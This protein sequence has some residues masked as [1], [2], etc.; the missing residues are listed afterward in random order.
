MAKR[1]FYVCAGI[2][3]LAAAYHL[4]ATRAESHAPGHSP[5]GCAAFWD[6]STDMERIAVATADGDVYWA[7]SDSPG[8]ESWMP[9]Q[10]V[11]SPIVAF[12]GWGVGNWGASA[13][14]ENGDVWRT[15]DP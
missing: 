3:M 5:V 11:P 1:F 4:G 8:G 13:I 14:A 2:L 6:A 9:G 7:D 15:Q 12:G 10:P